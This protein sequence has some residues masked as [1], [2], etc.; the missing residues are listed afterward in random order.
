MEQAKSKQEQIITNLKNDKQRLEK[1][2]IQTQ[3]DKENLLKL[4]TVDLQVQ[5]TNLSNKEQNT[6]ELHQQLIAQIQVITKN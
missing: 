5:Q 2:L 3:K 1:Q 4:L 6:Q